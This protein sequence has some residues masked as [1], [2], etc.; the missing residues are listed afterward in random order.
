[1]VR[2]QNDKET[3][4]ECGIIVAKR[5]RPSMKEIRAYEYMAGVGHC[6]GIVGEAWRKIVWGRI[7]RGCNVQTAHQ[8]P[9]AEA[10]WE[11]LEEIR[12]TTRAKDLEWRMLRWPE[13]YNPDG[14]LRDDNLKPF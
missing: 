6:E 5:K 10:L 11:I 14:T 9:I 13:H 3:S 2:N 8:T 7:Q 12:E 1:M 4:D